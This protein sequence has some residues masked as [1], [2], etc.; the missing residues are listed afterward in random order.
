MKY[1]KFLPVFAL[2]LLASCSSV[3]VATDYDSSVNFSQF[4]TY[5]FMKDGINKIDISD[6]DKKRILKA[7]DENLSA[8]G[9]VK[10]ENPDLLINLFT[11]AK[12][13]VNVNTFHGGWGYGFYRPWGWNPWMMGPGYQSVSTSTEGILFIDVLNAQNKELIWQGKGTGYL[14]NKQAKKEERIK[15]FT[16]KVLETFPSK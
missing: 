9:Y 3:Q 14:T 5:A 15:E 2:L 1:I 6:L 12:Q 11:D 16:T 8:K 7:I 13:V 4:K 10:S